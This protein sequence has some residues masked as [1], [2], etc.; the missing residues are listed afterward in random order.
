MD[1]LEPI[2][3]NNQCTIWCH[4]VSYAQIETTGVFLSPLSATNCFPIVLAWK[5][6]IEI[7]GEQWAEWITWNT[8]FWF[9]KHISFVNATCGA[10]CCIYLCIVNGYKMNTRPQPSLSAL[11]CCAML[12]NA[13]QLSTR[14]TKKT[15]KHKQHESNKL[16]STLLLASLKGTNTHHSL[17]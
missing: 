3:Q 11:F 16:R 2:V 9:H 4:R 17:S 15:P 1:V 10:Q 13:M 8:T 7:V 12:C 5:W 14:M 6:F